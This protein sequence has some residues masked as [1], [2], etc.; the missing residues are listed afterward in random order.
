MHHAAA[1]STFAVFLSGVRPLDTRLEKV[2]HLGQRPRGAAGSPCC[3]SPAQPLRSPFPPGKPHPCLLS[4]GCPG[5]LQPGPPGPARGRT[6]QCCKPRAPQG[7]EPGD[8]L[9]CASWWGMGKHLLCSRPGAPGASR[10]PSPA[11]PGHP[12]CH[13]RPRNFP[14]EELDSRNPNEGPAPPSALS[15]PPGRP[16][17][18]EGPVRPRLA[19]RR[20]ACR[21]HPGARGEPGR[22]CEVRPPV[23]TCTA[24]AHLFTALNLDAEV[25]LSLS[26]AVGL[27]WGRCPEAWATPGFLSQPHTGAHAVLGG[28]HLGAWRSAARPAAPGSRPEGAPWRAAWENPHVEDTQDSRGW[29]TDGPGHRWGQH[30]AGG[31][32]AWSWLGWA[33]PG[34]H[35][36]SH[37][38]V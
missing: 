17:P 15:T 29:S 26:A 4:P 27:I 3:P 7:R 21:Q 10:S 9:G 24:P 34:A 32:P 33:T 11:T 5:K 38:Q 30:R 16:H 37:R 18:R 14:G 13:P 2:V 31:N 22:R 25:K 23:R 36:V 28:T 1:S 20:R 6:F 8:T 19:G 35:G 12:G